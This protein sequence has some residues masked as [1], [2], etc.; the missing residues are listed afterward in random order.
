MPVFRL[1]Y[2]FNAIAGRV[3]DRDILQ[4]DILHREV[5]RSLGLEHQPEVYR[6]VDVHIFYKDVLKVSVAAMEPDGSEVLVIVYFV[7][8]S[9]AGPEIPA[10]TV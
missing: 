6:I 7:I 10:G 4:A 5:F 9:V 1:G 3:I 8:G 2:Q